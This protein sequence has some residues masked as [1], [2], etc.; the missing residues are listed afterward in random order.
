LLML[1]EAVASAAA[2][3]QLPEPSAF[4]ELVICLAVV[5]CMA[6]RQHRTSIRRSVSDAHH[7]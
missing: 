2:H 5:G 1:L 7:N 6:W 3:V 4:P